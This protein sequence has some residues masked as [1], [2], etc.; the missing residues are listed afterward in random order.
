[1]LPLTNIVLPI[2]FSLGSKGS[3]YHARTL[4]CRFQ[5]KVNLIHVLPSNDLFAGGV[6]L[7]GTI[8]TDWLEN[9]RQEAARRLEEFMST[10]FGSIPVNRLLFEGDPATEIVRYA[11]GRKADLIVMPTHGYGAFRR[12]ILGSV[13][14]K[15]LHDAHCPVFTGVHLEDSQAP[16]PIF[17]RKILCAVDLGAQS[18]HAFN[19]AANFAREFNAALKLVHILPPQDVGEARYFDQRWHSELFHEAKE[20][21]E[22]LLENTDIDVSTIIDH[23]DVASSLRKI[24][25]DEQANLLVIGRHVEHGLAGRLRTHGYA[26]TRE[27]PCPVVSV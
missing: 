25:A 6:E 10:E 18:V 20:R 24:A 16:R 19:W 15:V 13:T 12:F 21:L 3:G 22:Q 8:G 2:D 5:S 17:Y 11:D 27:S 26:I 9:R 23:G 14:A 7:P 4:A 1:M